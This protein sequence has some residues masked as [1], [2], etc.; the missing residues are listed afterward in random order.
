M[1]A[2][3]DGV[4]AG[5]FQDL[6]IIIASRLDRGPRPGQRLA[7]E[8]DGRIRVIDAPVSGGSEG[9]KAG[10]LSI[11]VG[12]EAGDVADPGRCSSRAVT[13]FIL[14][15]WCRPGCEACN[16]MIVAATVLALGEVRSRTSKRHRP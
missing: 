3:S 6:L 13:R 8:T 10:R 11:M 5:D 12:G 14:D 7:R 4:L 15:N 2:G 16:Q 1:L 9:A